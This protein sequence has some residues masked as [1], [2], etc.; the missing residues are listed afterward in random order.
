MSGKTLTLAVL[1][2]GIALLAVAVSLE[3][4]T[5]AMP[6]RQKLWD[7]QELQNAL[8]GGVDSDVIDKLGEPDS[9]SDKYAPPG[10]VPGNA[11]WIYHNRTRNPQTGRP[12]HE[13]HVWFEHGQVRRILFDTM[14]EIPEHRPAVGPGF[15]H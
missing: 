15:A 3:L 9:N 7:R 4:A 12:D 11:V 8:L 10:T 13:I 1:L 14:S 6:A 2:G 5:R